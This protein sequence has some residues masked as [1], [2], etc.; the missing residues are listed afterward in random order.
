M[1]PDSSDNPRQ[2]AIEQLQTFGLSAYAAET[3]VT[4]VK[5]ESGTAQDIS[6]LSEVPRTRVYDAVDE[7]EQQGLVDVQHSNPKQFWAVSEGTTCQHF[8]QYFTQRLNRLRDAF[9]ALET[10]IRS[11]EQRGVWTVTGRGTIT[12]RIR[13]FID[14]ANERIVF[15]SVE[16][17]L[18]EEIIASLAAAQDRGVSIRLG[19]MSESSRREIETAVPETEFVPSLWNWEE[20]P[21]GRLLMVDDEATLVSVLVPDD[22]EPVG[23]QTDETA[24]W[25]TGVNNNLVVV[26]RALFTW[27]LDS[28]SFE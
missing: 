14:A 2:V 1:S 12:E 20:T 5:I 28:S 11:K 13:E 17:L 6:D 15:M 27:Q 4:L 16:G 9:G 22:G 3:F 25:G 21:S 18:T 8:E 7:L 24:I 19:E 23:K 26:L 10:N